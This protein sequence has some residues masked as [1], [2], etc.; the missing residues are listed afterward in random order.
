MADKD[1]TNKVLL[2][3]IQAI[4]Y[5]LEKR[6]DKIETKLGNLEYKVDGLEHKVDQ[7]FEEAKEHRRILQE[8]LEATILMPYKHNKK[9]AQLSSRA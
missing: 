8:D 7:G 9:I 6:M 5:S 3:H 2:E 4:K 1:I